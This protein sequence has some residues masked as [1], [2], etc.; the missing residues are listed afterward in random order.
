MCRKN[1]LSYILFFLRCSISLSFPAVNDGY[2][3]RFISQNRHIHFEV[4]E[5][6]CKFSSPAPSTF[7]K[8]PQPR[9][10]M[11]LL[12]VSRLY[13]SES[14]LCSIKMPLK[15]N[16]WCATR[17][18]TKSKHTYMNIHTRTYAYARTHACTY[19][20]THTRANSH[21]GKCRFTH[22]SYRS[23]THAR[24]ITVTVEFR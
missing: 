13:A 2:D 24:S 5:P 4:C 20:R 6:Y 11:L 3:S 1:V 9:Q 10:N 16:T 12:Q 21:P 22:M 23:A 19:T 15:S 7:L 8:P 17:K 18:C 14:S